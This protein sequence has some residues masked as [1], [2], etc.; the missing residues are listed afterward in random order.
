MIV[1]FD[2]LPFSEKNAWRIKNKK[3]NYAPVAEERIAELKKTFESS[4]NSIEVEKLIK[5][6]HMI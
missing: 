1:Q 5:M 3:M 6:S 4:V 2:N